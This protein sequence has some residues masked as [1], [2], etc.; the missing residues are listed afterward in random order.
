M[1]N[2]LRLE[3]SLV[4]WSKFEHPSRSV[5]C[6]KDTRAEIA[7]LAVVVARHSHVIAKVVDAPDYF[8]GASVYLVANEHLLS[9]K[10]LVIDY[11]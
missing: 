4:F 3:V 5:L 11:L 2:K 9:C 6:Q 8:G 7:G 10:N 1:D